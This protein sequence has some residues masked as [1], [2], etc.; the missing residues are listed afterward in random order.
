MMNNNVNASVIDKIN[1]ILEKGY[2]KNILCVV[3]M[4]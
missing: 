3:L 1:S 2:N 4:I